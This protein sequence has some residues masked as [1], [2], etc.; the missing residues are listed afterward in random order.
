MVIIYLINTIIFNGA[1]N[2]FGIKPRNINGLVGIVVSPFLH[3]NLAHLLNNLVGF[4]I[5]SMLIMLQGLR[6]YWRASVI[7]IVLG[8]LGVWLFGRSSVH[9]GAS[10]WIFGLWALCIAN[11]WFTR[12]FKN[13]VIAALVVLVW[14]GMVF[15]VLPKNTYVSFEAHLMGAIAGI[16]AAAMLKKKR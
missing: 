3:A 15:G 10:G 11:A 4:S 14:G 12:N 1:L 9:I 2:N 7:I 13:F 6:Y 5:F 8:G 16:I